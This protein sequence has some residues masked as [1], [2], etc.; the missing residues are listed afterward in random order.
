[1]VNEIKG[2]QSNNVPRALT[3]GGQSQANQAGNRP[4]NT[5]ENRE[6]RMDSP[7]NEVSLTDTAAKLRELEAKIAN[8]PVVDTKRVE[9]IKKAISEGTYQVNA[10]RTADKMASFES[11]LSSKSGDK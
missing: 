5:A 6:G 1:M 9:G 7:A 10:S 3:V 2:L 8:Q 11:L 4:A